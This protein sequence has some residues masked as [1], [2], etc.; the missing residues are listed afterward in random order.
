MLP[1]E[2]RGDNMTDRDILMIANS[3][4]ETLYS[5]IINVNKNYYQNSVLIPKGSDSF[6]LPSD[7]VY[8][9]TSLEFAQNK[10]TPEMAGRKGYL[11]S[12]LKNC[13]PVYLQYN[14]SAYKLCPISKS[15][16]DGASQITERSGNKHFVASVPTSWNTGDEI[17]ISGPGGFR[18][19]QIEDRDE[20][21]VTLKSPA[22][23]GDYISLAGE[24]PVIDLPETLVPVLI[25]K[26]IAQCF[27]SLGDRDGAG[28][29]LNG[30][31]QDEQNALLNLKIQGG[32]LP[33][34]RA[35]VW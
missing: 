8:A 25:Q 20:L 10:F 24:S 27:F 11:P 26:T 13:Y 5:R 17:T 23:T 19:D 4:S 9:E 30:V 3:I 31:E 1:A 35:E 14:R 33:V 16:E 32:K 28:F 34:F 29:A 2:E 15:S 6:M 22:N 21:S 7:A 18:T 12:E